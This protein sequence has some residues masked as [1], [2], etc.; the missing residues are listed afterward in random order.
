MD[1]ALTR[2]SALARAAAFGGG[3]L[4]GGALLGLLAPGA[5]AA[6]LAKGDIEILNFALTL[7][8]LESAFYTEAESKGKLSGEL[9]AFATQ[10]G[11]NERAHVALLKQVLGAK[12]VKKPKFNFHGAT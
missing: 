3:L 6:S 11:A 4:G 5:R 12:A 10:V 1:E 8:Y 2:S 7:E 9:A